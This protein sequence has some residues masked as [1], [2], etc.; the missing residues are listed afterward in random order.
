MDPDLQGMRAF[1]I[2]AEELHFGRAAARLLLTQQ[3]LSKRVRRLENSLATPLFARTTRKVE[4]TAAGHRLLPL[5]RDAVAAFDTAVAAV[6]PQTP[7]ALR[8]DVFAERFTPLALLREIAD[9]EPDLGVEPS[10]RQGLAN[11]LPAV[12]NGELDAAFGRVNDAARPWPAELA[13][14]PVSVVA[15]Y[16]FAFE[17]HALADRPALRIADLKEAGIAMP[18]P[19]G[20]DEW[21]AYLARLSEGLGVPVRYGEV[22][23]GVRDSARQ[24]QRERHGVAVGE[25]DIDLPHYPRLRQIPIVEPT[26]LHV[27]SI[28][29]HRENRDPRL[30]RL[31]RAL[32]RPEAPPV[33]TWLPD[34]DRAALNRRAGGPA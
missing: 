15:L 33:G 9:R 24:L 2:V 11:A 20:A 5:A 1:V 6:R 28:V 32:P 8:V 4:L 16:A 3:A 12:L 7:T 30:A 10:M 22:A 21:R 13:H 31:L 17:G 29:W 23:V 14:R 18:D 34:E 27:W 19:G 25:K 26:P